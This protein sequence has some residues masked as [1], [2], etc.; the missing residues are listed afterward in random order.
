MATR[1]LTGFI[2]LPLGVLLAGCAGGAGQAE[3]A[4][5]EVRADAERDTAPA[6]PADDLHALVAG[7]TAFALALYQ[8]VRGD[9]DNLFCSP[10]SVS[11][12]LAMAY[13]GA[14]GLTAEQMAA[15]L[16]YTLAADRLHPA[17]NAL[18]LALAPP[19]RQEGPGRPFTLNVANAIWGQRDHPWA[20]PFLDL[21]ARHY[22]AGLRVVD[23]IADAEAARRTINAWVSERT[24]QR[25]P[26]L[27]AQG[28]LNQDTRL[29][30]TNAI[31]FLADWL[32]PFQ[33]ENTTDADFHLRDGAT[34]AVPMMHQTV[35]HAY[36]EG[37]GWQAVQLD[38]RG[39]DVSMLLI[40]PAAGA[41][42]T[43]EAAL[44][45]ERL[46]TITEALAPR[47][48]ALGLPKFEFSTD[49]SLGQVLGAMG[50][51][52]AFD[53]ATADFSGM[54]GGVG[55]LF[56]SAVIHK[57]F[58]KVDEKGT[59]AAAA[60]AIGMAGTGMPM[61]QVTLTFDR[62]FLCLLRHRPTG[63]VLFLGRVLDPR[64]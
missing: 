62:P 2:C 47:Q 11:L 31:Y 5:A 30:L 15:T 7:N 20:A 3:A 51:P 44:T 29:V 26:E 28:L 41:F 19:A 21:L 48:V 14:R 27:L 63:A 13:A 25:I 52:A 38:Y 10:H 23:F 36:A 55:G 32:A 53:P 9:H 45:P 1:T 37:N 12:A 24:N 50:M 40:L 43:F 60:T 42:E 49:L 56:I 58:V 59:E 6:V 8:A 57:A 22:G 61:D 39:G 4:A 54:D 33:A 18:D 16:H 64:G 35:R 46:M 34:V 17:F